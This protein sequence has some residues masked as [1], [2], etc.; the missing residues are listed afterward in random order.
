MSGIPRIDVPEDERRAIF[1]YLRRQDP[2]S[3]VRT[4]TGRLY[5]QIVLILSSFFSVFR[6][7]ALVN[8]FAARHV[9]R[10]ARNFAHIRL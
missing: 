9:V 7:C 8:T 3:K 1:A 2:A 5:G 10:T 6:Y 4:S